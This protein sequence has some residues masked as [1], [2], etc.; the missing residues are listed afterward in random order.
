MQEVPSIGVK[1][2]REIQDAYA[3]AGHKRGKT[4]YEMQAITWVAWKRIHN[5]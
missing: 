3:V 4:A 2:R 1:L 5:V